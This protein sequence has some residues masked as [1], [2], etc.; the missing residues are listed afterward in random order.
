MERGQKTLY[1]KSSILKEVVGCVSSKANMKVGSTRLT[2]ELLI[3]QLEKIEQCLASFPSRYYLKTKLSS[4]LRRGEP[5]LEELEICR[6]IVGGQYKTLVAQDARNQETREKT[7]ISAPTQF[8]TTATV[9]P[10]NR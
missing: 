3:D 1:D 7:I 8:N 5:I 2:K 10:A 9:V 6:D 4:M